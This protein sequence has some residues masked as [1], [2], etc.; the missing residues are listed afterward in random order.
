MTDRRSDAD[1]R[2]ASSARLKARW[3]DP[4]QRAKMLEAASLGCERAA[5]LIKRRQ[6][7]PSDPRQKSKFNLVRSVCGI[8]EARRVFG[9]R[10]D[11]D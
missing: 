8:D 5:Q 11:H 6:P 9:L 7:T 3:A 4:I 10:A 2:A 1:T